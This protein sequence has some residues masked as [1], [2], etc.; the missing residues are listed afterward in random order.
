MGLAK[1]ELKYLSKNLGA[2]LVGV[3]SRD[4]LAGGPPSA[5][6]C[7]LLPSANSVISFAVSLDTRIAKDF[8]SKKDWKSHCD[9]RK[10]IARKLYRISD[11]LVVHLR[12]KGHEAVNVDSTTTIDLKTALPT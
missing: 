10:R 12:S 6:P 2:D 4:I 7:Y 1:T 11:T 8:I 5:D 9:D 3:T